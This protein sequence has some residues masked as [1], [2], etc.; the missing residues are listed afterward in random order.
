VSLRL[1]SN[2]CGRLPINRSSGFTMGAF[3]PAGT[4]GAAGAGPPPPGLPDPLEPPGVLHIV[5]CKLLA[6]R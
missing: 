1:P 4:A 3:P 6:T 2:S 5:V